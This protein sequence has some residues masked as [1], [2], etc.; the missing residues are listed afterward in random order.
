MLKQVIFQYGLPFI[1][2]LSSIFYISTSKPISSTFF[3]SDTNRDPSRDDRNFIENFS[4]NPS[5]EN[6]FLNTGYSSEIIYLLGS[7]ELAENSNAIPY[8]FIS[9]HFTTKVKA[10]GHA[11]NQCFSIFAQLLANEERLN[12]APVVIIISPGWFESKPSKGTSSAIFL[13]FNSERFLNKIISTIGINKFKAYMYQ[14]VADLY[15][16]FSSPNIELKLMN[17]E[18]CAAKSLAH[19]LLYSPIILCDKKLLK[20]KENILDYKANG[21]IHKSRFPINSQSI[22]IKW[23]SLFEASKVEVTS[24]STNNSLGISNDY[25]TE[26]IHGKVGKI[27]AVNEN[28]NQELAD[29]LMLLSLIKEKHVNASFIISPLNAY[30]FKNLNELS[31]IIKTVETNIKMCELPLLNLFEADKQ[32]YDK[33]IL[34][35]VMHLSDFG[36]YRADKFIVDTYHLNQ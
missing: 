33:A 27:Q 23:D 14:R 34:H 22:Q 26:Y 25:Y 21:S 29:F 9:Q 2:A 15:S 28:I 30:Y 13:E 24:N 1:I 16:D 8:N 18:H 4:D 31:P 35:D 3:I 36:W 19:Q 7:S 5:W 32:K 17:F 20:I 11:G 12:K 6:N 10:I